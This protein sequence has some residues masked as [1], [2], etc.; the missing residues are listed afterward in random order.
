MGDN[1]DWAA[2]HKGETRKF[3]RSSLSGAVGPHIR[4]VGI[5]GHLTASDIVDELI[6][7]ALVVAIAVHHTPPSTED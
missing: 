7:A 5:E 4:M 6:T 1:D 2:L 3:L